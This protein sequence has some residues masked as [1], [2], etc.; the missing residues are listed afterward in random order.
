M[1]PRTP[2]LKAKK[3]LGQNWMVD[4]VAINKVFEASGLGEMDTVVEVGP[5]K[6]SLTK[7]LVKNTARV[8]A[9]EMDQSLSVRLAKAL[10]DPSNLVVINEDARSWDP[11]VVTDPYKL[12]S[13]LPYY[14]ATPIIRNFLESSNPPSEITITIQKEVAESMV[15]APG[16]MRTLSVATQL[17]GN[18]RIV[19]YIDP[20]SFRPIPKVTSAIVKIEVYKEPLLTLEDTESFFKIVRAGFRNP[21]KKLRNSLSNALDIH[22]SDIEDALTQVSVD[23]NLRPESLTMDEWNR[24]CDSLRRNNLC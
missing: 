5:G 12:I 1:S 16:K 3:S 18:P 8:I 23:H 14:A 15:A 10:N 13:N 24:I 4:N 6:G 20:S 19:D 11:S 22:T 7:L 2:N 9:V 21:R 17:Y